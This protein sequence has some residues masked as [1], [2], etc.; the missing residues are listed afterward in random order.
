VWMSLSPIYFTGENLVAFR[1]QFHSNLTIV[2]G[3]LIIFLVG[4]LITKLLKRRIATKTQK[5]LNII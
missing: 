3:T 2:F 5:E 1:S 4:F